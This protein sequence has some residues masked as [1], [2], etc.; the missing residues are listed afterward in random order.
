M[1]RE[2]AKVSSEIENAFSKADNLD[3]ARLK[4]EYLDSP[5]METANPYQVLLSLFWP[6]DFAKSEDEKRDVAGIFCK[7]LFEKDIVPSV[8][9]QL[10]RNPPRYAEFAE[11][12]L[13]VLSLFEDYMLEKHGKSGVRYYRTS[14]I[15]SFAKIGRFDIAMNF[16]SW[17]KH[18]RETLVSAF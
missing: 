17:T 3:L 7:K 11:D 2:Y 15:S 13:V 16:D 8:P 10:W 9:H 14:A 1:E 12:S 4:K 6:A 18:A 5:S